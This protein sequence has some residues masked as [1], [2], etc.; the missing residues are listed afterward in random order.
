MGGEDGGI[1]FNLGEFGVGEEEGDV[2]VANM[3]VVVGCYAAVV[4]K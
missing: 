2:E 4:G 3:G 1:D